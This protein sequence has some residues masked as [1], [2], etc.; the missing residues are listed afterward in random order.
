[1]FSNAQIKAD[2]DKVL[3]TT[4]KSNVFDTEGKFV[5]DASTEKVNKPIDLPICSGVIEF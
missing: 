1:M 3:K 5:F 4:A 2:P